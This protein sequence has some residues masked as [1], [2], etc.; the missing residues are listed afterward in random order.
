MFLNTGG[1]VLFDSII[2][3]GFEPDEYILEVDSDLA[4]A[5]VKHLKMYKGWLIR[6]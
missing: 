6:I 5:A 3:P 4:K 1:R 2:C